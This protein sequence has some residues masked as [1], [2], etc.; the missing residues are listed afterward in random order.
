M[1]FLQL[2]PQV[3][4]MLEPYECE[5]L[6]VKAKE[7]YE[8]DHRL[9]YIAIT[10]ALGSAFGKNYKYNDIFKKSNVKKEVDEEEKQRMKEY[11][12]NW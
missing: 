1:G 12:E 6:L 2:S 7:R 11:F 5:E 3:F 10:N 4:F 8:F 9:M